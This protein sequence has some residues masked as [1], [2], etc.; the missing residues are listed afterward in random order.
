MEDTQSSVEIS[1]E[2]S[3]RERKIINIAAKKHPRTREFIQANLPQWPEVSNTCRK[4]GK[5]I[6]IHIHPRYVES[7]SSTDNALCS[8]CNPESYWYTKEYRPGRS[9][10]KVE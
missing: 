4:C 5:T 6:Y 7:M 2:K 1:V 10:S 3:I 9:I 8:N